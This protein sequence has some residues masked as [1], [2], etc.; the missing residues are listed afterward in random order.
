MKLP[1]YVHT[2]TSKPKVECSNKTKNKHEWGFQHPAEASRALSLRRPWTW[3][4]RA[5]ITLQEKPKDNGVGAKWTQSLRRRS[6]SVEGVASLPC[7]FFLGTEPQGGPLRQS[8]LPQAMHPSTRSSKLFHQAP[9]LSRAT[10]T[11]PTLIRS[12]TQPVP[13]LLGSGYIL[14]F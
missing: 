14:S 1:R 9:P 2:V 13:F 8:S 4:P 5:H 12:Y 6:C 10:R 3:T 7:P 11:P